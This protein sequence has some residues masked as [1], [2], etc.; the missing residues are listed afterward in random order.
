MRPLPNPSPL[1]QPFWD[2]ARDGHLVRQV[3]RA[4]GK[5]FFSPQV[6]C[7][8]CLSEVWDWV[9][10]SGRGEVYSRTVVHRAPS[11]GFEIP[12]VYAVIDLEEGWSMMANVIGCDTAEV[13][14]GMPVTV[15]FVDLGSIVLPAFEPAR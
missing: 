12:Y 1:T 10:S 6:A 5:S 14:I 8:G 9:P 7:P 11:A 2:A 15:T 4:C 13:A 3:C